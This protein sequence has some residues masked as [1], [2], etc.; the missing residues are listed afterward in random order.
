M[1]DELSCSIC[2]ELYD[3]TLRIPTNLFPCGHVF[4]HQCLKKIPKKICSTCKVNYTQTSVNWSL[5]NLVSRSD[6]SVYSS[7]IKELV[8]QNIVQNFSCLNETAFKKCKSF[9]ENISAKMIDKIEE[10]NQRNESYKK[11]FAHELNML[12]EHIN[13]IYKENSTICSK[14]T[15]KINA[16]TVQANRKNSN[17]TKLK[18]T[19]Q[20]VQNEISMLK[21]KSLYLE[22]CTI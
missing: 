7:K 2:F 14:A 20:D 8:G 1:H 11:A 17:E 5:K 22:V 10:I 6:P 13:S 12:D 15:K 4:C 3:E 18:N 19:Y 21:E 9:I 16:W